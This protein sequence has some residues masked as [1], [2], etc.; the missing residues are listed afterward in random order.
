MDS[1]V[2]QMELLIQNYMFVTMA[3]GEFLTI[4]YDYIW[5]EIVVLF[6]D[7]LVEGCNQKSHIC[8]RVLFDVKV[9][10]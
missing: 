6:K 8:I 10:K 7:K 3:L 4:F 5:K 1:L 2:L 9:S